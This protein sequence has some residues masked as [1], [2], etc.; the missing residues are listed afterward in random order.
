MDDDAAAA[1]GAAGTLKRLRR[2]RPAPC[3]LRP[4]PP[5]K[6]FRPKGVCG[7]LVS[8]GPNR[9][10]SFVTCKEPDPSWQAGR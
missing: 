5:G 2:L 1:G 3:A 4:A 6:P 7:P 10:E 8:V 9:H